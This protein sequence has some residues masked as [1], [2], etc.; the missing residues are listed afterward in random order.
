[1]SNSLGIV[2]SAITWLLESARR[3]SVHR[4]RPSWFL[5]DRTHV[6]KR[7]AHSNR[8]VR[9]ASTILA[10]YMLAFTDRTSS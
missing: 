6:K 7:V 4:S 3:L 1:M 2:T 10:W 5:L 8:L 9:A